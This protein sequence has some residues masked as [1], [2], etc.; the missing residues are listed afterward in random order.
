VTLVL[1]MLR[2]P[3]A[4]PPETREVK[5]GEFSIGR[6]ADNDW[7]LA[8]PERHLSKR[9]CVL[10]FRA[11]GWQLADLSTNGTFLNRESD[12][13]G[14]G[15]PRSLRDGDRLHLG[16]YEI[17]VRL[18]ETEA[19]MVAA[20]PAQPSDD[21]FGDDPFRPPPAPFAEPQPFSGVVSRDAVQ[22]PSDFDPMAPEAGE[23]GFGAPTQADHT[24]GLEDAF[25]PPTPGGSMLPDDWD[26]DLPAAAPARPMPGPTTGF[27]GVSSSAPPPVQ[28]SFAPA[29]PPLTA[30]P[31]QHVPPPPPPPAGP[32]AEAMLDPL[33]EPLLAPA[34]R[35]PAAVP[36]PAPAIP[37]AEPDEFAELET[38]ASLPQPPPPAPVA[39]RIPPSA[40]AAPAAVQSAGEPADVS[41]LDS[42]LRGVGLS[43]AKLGNPAA[44]FEELG[45]AFRVLVAELR[46]TLIARA[47]IKGEFRIEQTMIRSSGNNPLKFSAGDDD[48]ITALLGTGRRV[49]MK[50]SAA[51]ADALGDLRLHE[52]AT[53]AAMQSAV[54]ALLA[55][56]DPAALRREAEQGGM[57]LVPVQ[58]KARAWDSFEKL[59]ARISQA[60]AD[61]FDSVFGKAFARA[62][63]QALDEAK[64]REGPRS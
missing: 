32:P 18:A 11:G 57:A 42:F 15:Q 64:G 28:P 61:D 12:A 25:R 8:D 50:P 19:P 62:Y 56:F 63:E 13:I 14:P 47:A 60:L 40:A 43:D 55:Q 51:I 39:P 36:P 1:S 26:L 49:D 35:P 46:A 29:P 22:L 53:M 31:R 21:P 20:R 44:T 3:D 24:S 9:H 23:A 7:V 41:L 10:A 27:G 16:A 5:G 45:R 2:C 48:A 37:P 6:G 4:V 59:H 17:E 33:D 54:R 34:P 52:L 38:S 58:R 30:P